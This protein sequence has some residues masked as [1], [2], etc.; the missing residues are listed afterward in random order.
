MISDM[1]LD[2]REE[3]T[4]NGRKRLEVLTGREALNMENRVAET[5]SVGQW[6]KM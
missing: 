4:N 3:E 6:Q 5:S 1:M 2:L